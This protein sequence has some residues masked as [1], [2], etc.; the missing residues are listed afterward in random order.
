MLQIVCLP[1]SLPLPHSRS[2]SLSKL[3]EH[4]KKILK[5]KGFEFFEGEN[6]SLFD[7]VSPVAGAVPHTQQAFINVG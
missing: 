1:L 5:R 2:V 4:F 6:G 7:F 3:N